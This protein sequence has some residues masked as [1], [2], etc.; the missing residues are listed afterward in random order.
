[1]LAHG[2]VHH[3]HHVRVPNNVTF[4]P[5]SEHSDHSRTSFRLQIRMA[6]R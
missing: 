2:T 3:A 4:L 5:Y 1:M 6:R